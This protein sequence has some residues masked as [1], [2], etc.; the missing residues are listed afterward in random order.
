MANIPISIV[1]IPISMKPVSLFSAVS[2]PLAPVF[3][4]FFASLIPRLYFVYPSISLLLLFY[5]FRV[6]LVWGV[7]SQ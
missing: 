1:F 6:L 4:P 5:C 3:R 7:L 2:G